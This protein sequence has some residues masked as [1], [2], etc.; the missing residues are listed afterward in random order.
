MVFGGVGSDNI[1]TGSGND[2]VLGD[3]GHAVYNASGTLTYLTTISP[4]IGGNDVIHAGDGNNYIFGGTG[5][6]RI[7]G[8]N[9]VDVVL[10]DN[11]Y[12]TF[13]DLGV[14]T[15]LTTTDESFGGNDIIFTYGG[16]DMIFGGGGND[17]IDAGAGDD[18]V[19]GDFG[20]YSIAHVNT[21]LAQYQL[22]DQLVAVAVYPHGVSVLDEING[23]NDTI[24]GGSGNDYLL[25]EGGNDYIDGGSGDDVIYGGYGDDLLFG[26][27]GNDALVG[28]PG[29]DFLD[30][31]SGTNILYV[32]L[33]DEW[34]G[35]M[36]KDT[37]VGGPYFSTNNQLTFG[38]PAMGAAAGQLPPGA[39]MGARSFS[40]DSI[41][42]AGSRL[43]I[44]TGSGN[45]LAMNSGSSTG[46][47]SQFAMSTPSAILAPTQGHTVSSSSINHP[48]WAGSGSSFAPLASDILGATPLMGIGEFL[49]VQWS[50][51]MD[52]YP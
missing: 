1:T 5:N 32:D 12:A 11:G 7:Y 26:G 40:S 41:F 15:F 47:G 48:R 33:F 39:S 19:L 6:D 37:I 23:G 2:F 4:A 21:P 22:G 34:A 8:G 52:V 36:D 14:L 51:R 25:G 31:G 3:N 9:G 27:D 46:S 43:G 20:Y 16:N 18:V 42:L 50:E 38:L 44:I 45:Q 24:L 35:G 49:E 28:G 17:Y 13:S 29:G 30:G 10:G